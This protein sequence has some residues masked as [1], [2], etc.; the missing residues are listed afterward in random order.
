MRGG[1]VEAIGIEGSTGPETYGDFCAG[2]HGSEGEG[3]V[4]PALLEN[5]FVDGST[6]QELT[7]LILVGR[8]GTAMVSFEG[9]IG[10]D[11]IQDLIDL[12]RTWQSTLDP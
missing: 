3:G 12:L 11:Q 6:D 1:A 5:E 4:G 10:Q 9:K 7:E 8:P 2:C